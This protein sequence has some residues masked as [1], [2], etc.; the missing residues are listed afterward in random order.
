MSKLK[1]IIKQLSPKNYNSIYDSLIESNAEKSAYLLKFM[2]EKQLSDTKIM[3]ELD[4][5]TNAYYTLRSRLNQKIEE[6]L[7]HQM[8]SPRTT[9]LKKVATINEIVF[10]KKKAIALA[11]LRKLEKELLDYD[12]SN[13]LTIIYKTLKKLQINSPDQFNYSQLYNRHVAYMLAVDKAE[14]LLAEYFKKLGVYFLTYDE[15]EKLGLTLLKKEL[16][17]VSNLYQS[18]RLY[19]Y[20]SCLNIYHWLFVE[21]SINSEGQQDPIEDIFDKVQTIFDSYYLDP[22]YYHLKLVF[23]YLKLEYYT[24]V[25]VYRKAEKYYEEV[26]ETAAIFISNY[27]LYTF[28][29]QFLLTK[30]ERHMRL[31]NENLLYEENK[32][33]FEDFDIDKNNV[34]QYII[35]VLYRAI[36]CYYGDKYDEAAKYV[37]NML[38]DLS[39][40]KYPYTQLEIKLFLALQYCLMKDYDLFNQLVNSIQRQVRLLG[41]GN[42]VHI[43]L[44][45]KILKTSLNDVKKSKSGKIQGYIQ[46]IK[47]INPPYFSPL[48]Y[49]KLDEDFINRLT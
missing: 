20:M 40:K 16:E 11:T 10:T 1:N 23:E 14:D 17:N 49:L 31:E 5:N 7:L 38:N 4:V 46:K 19:I 8:E 39:L 26:N 42:C 29:P 6:Y 2:R 3:E 30:L 48:K 24:N 13:E 25:A 33:I 41:K 21:K 36:S 44:F 37:N 34:P 12:L 18:H 35:Y 32:S 15:T 43:L 28:T 47:A 27:N 9:L 22:I 45:T